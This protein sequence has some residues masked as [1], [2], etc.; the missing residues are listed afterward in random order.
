MRRV[1]ALRKGKLVLQ[2]SG[3]ERRGSGGAACCAASPALSSGS[4]L[5]CPHL[6]P[7]SS[8]MESYH[9]WAPPVTARW[10]AGCIWEAPA[11]TPFRKAPRFNGENA[12]ISVIFLF[13]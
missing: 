2:P 7:R 12:T 6:G 4:T 5:V 9:R 10:V 11:F 13:S 8:F 3:W 1:E